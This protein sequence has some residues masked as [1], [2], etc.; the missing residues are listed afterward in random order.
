MKKNFKKALAILLALCTVLTLLT[1]CGGEAPP[2]MPPGEMLLM[3]VAP[4]FPAVK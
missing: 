4:V 3:A 1:A 2:E